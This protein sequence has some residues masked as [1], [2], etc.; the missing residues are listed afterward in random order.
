[1][2]KTVLAAMMVAV[3][4][5]ADQAPDPSEVILPEQIGPAM[6]VLEVRATVRDTRVPIGDSI[7]VDVHVRNPSAEPVEIVSACVELIYLSALRGDDEIG[8]DGSGLCRTSI[9]VHRFAPGEVKV[10][11]QRVWARWDDDYTPGHYRMRVRTW[12][13]AGVPEVDA[14]FEVR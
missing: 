3:A 11:P 1:M 14:P 9:T 8:L 7:V 5:C 10:I 4:S 12:A 2:R 13:Y 6:D